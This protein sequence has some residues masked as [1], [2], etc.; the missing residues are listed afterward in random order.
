MKLAGGTVAIGKTWGVKV[1]AGVAADDVAVL[2]LVEGAKERYGVELASKPAESGACFRLTVR[3]GA[4][5]V[6]ATLDPDKEAI[7]LQ[8]YR[9]EVGE[10]EVH[11]TAN[12][13]AGLFYG[14]E[15]V[16][17]LM[18]RRDGGIALPLGEIV[19]WPDVELRE[20]FW[21]DAHHLETMEALK[22]AIRQAAFYKVNGFV[23]KLDGHFQY[24][25]APAVVEP[26]ALRPRSCRSSRIT[27][28]TITCN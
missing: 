12:A 6:G 8:A 13:P 16:V 27:R 14:V 7:A 3:A 1:D 25:S 4:V 23:L 18:T 22:K 21:D 10:R 11:I 9:V 2:A 17:Q 5:A 28:S 26:Q 20:I 19:D 24:H 15:T